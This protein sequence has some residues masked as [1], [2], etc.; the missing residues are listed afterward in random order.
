[1]VVGIVGIGD[2]LVAVVR[3]VADAYVLCCGIFP[4]N[5]TVFVILFGFVFFGCTLSIAVIVLVAPMLLDEPISIYL[6]SSCV[7]SSLRPSSL[8]LT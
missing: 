3:V 1:M 2:F 6:V 4:E 8:C 5:D 7:N